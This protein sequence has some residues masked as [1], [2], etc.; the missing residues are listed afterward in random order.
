MNRVCIFTFQAR[1]EGELFVGKLWIAIVAGDR[2]SS[3]RYLGIAY[4]G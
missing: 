2:A 1:L 4:Q 3:D